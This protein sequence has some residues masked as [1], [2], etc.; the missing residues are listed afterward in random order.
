MLQTQ[1]HGIHVSRLRIINYN[2]S[3]ASILCETRVYSWHIVPLIL[4][5][6]VPLIL[7][8]VMLHVKMTLSTLAAITSLEAHTIVAF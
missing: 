7:Q 1:R 6:I 5:Y 8:Q 2:H 3:Q 4:Y